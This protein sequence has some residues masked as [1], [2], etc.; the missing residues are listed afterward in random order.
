MVS[1]FWAIL[2]YNN[3]SMPDINCLQVSIC[4]PLRLRVSGLSWLNALGRPQDQPV[5]SAK[6]NSKLYKSSKL[7][8]T[9]LFCQLTKEGPQSSSAPR[10]MRASCQPC[11]VT[12]RL[13][14]CYRRTHAEIQE[15]WPKWFNEGKGRTQSLV[16]SNILSIPEEIPKMYGL[17]RIHR[18]NIPLRTIVASRG[19]LTVCWQICFA[20]WWANQNTT[21]RT[22]VILWTKLRT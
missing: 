4:Q 11:S 12:P 1:V 14:K 6:A 10:I 5:T 13:M 21:S 2:S 8:L 20:P 7:T 22:V 9:S 3:S 19:S 16:L 18:A 17:P 15:N